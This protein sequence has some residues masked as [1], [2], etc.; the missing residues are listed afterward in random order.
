MRLQLLE[1]KKFPY[2]IKVLNGI[3]ML[4]PQSKAFEALDD[5]LKSIQKIVKIF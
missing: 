4:L 2:L 5:R 1:F 3:L